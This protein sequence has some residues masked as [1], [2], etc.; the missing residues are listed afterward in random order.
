MAQ[1]CLIDAQMCT[2]H[3]Y[4]QVP[5]RLVPGALKL[6]EAAASASLPGCHTSVQY[7]YVCCQVCSLTG[8]L[9]LVAEAFPWSAG[10]VFTYTVDNHNSVVG[11]REEALAAGATAQAVLPTRSQGERRTLVQRYA[12]MCRALLL[13]GRAEGGAG[14]R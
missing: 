14:G 11:M 2:F 9:K 1:F 8:A 4:I 3:L 10:S 12:A 7:A 5:R 6:S 13:Q